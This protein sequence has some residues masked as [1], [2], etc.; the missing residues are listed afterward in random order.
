MRS[1]FYEDEDFKLDIDELILPD[2]GKCLY[3][4]CD[5]YTWKLSVL[6]KLYRVASDVDNY[7]DALGYDNII[8]ISPNPKFA[9]LLG[10][11]S[12]MEMKIDG[13]NYEMIKWELK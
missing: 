1:T 2:L 5:V 12:I 13:I 4:H 9:K 3:V 10:G 8:T 11:Y 6:K 7:K